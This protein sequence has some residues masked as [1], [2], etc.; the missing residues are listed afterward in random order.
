M[1]FDT[2]RQA[3]E[4]PGTQ[5]AGPISFQNLMDGIAK[6]YGISYK[7]FTL[8]GLFT[9]HYPNRYKT[10]VRPYFTVIFTGFINGNNFSKN[11]R[12]QW[13]EP[14]KIKQVVFYPASVMIVEK[15]VKE[16]KTVWAGAFEEYGYT[17]PLTDPSVVKFRIIEPFYRLK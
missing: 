4:V 7:K 17:N 15:L 3:W 12:L 9:Y 10:V 6:E 16:P 8:S 13:F 11:V 2:N 5:Y 1:V 14:D